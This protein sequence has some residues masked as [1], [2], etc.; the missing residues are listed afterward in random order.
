MNNRYKVKN[1]KLQPFYQ[2]ATHLLSSFDQA[3]IVHISR[4]DNRG[5]DVLAFNAI[6][7]K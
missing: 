6:R 3:E 4:S 2:E 5:A 7:Q 1:T